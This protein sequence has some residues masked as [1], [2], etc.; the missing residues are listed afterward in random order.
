MSE[1]DSSVKTVESA[2]SRV[3]R[4]SLTCQPGKVIFTEQLRNQAKCCLAHARVHVRLYVCVYVRVCVCLRVYVCVCECMCV[5]VFI[6]HKVV[7]INYTE[8]IKKYNT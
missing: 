8:I 4:S 6:H 7:V 5:C 3:V 2:A 1:T